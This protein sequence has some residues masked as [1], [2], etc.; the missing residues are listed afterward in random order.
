MPA[1]LP[2][3]P[4][5]L[6]TAAADP[7]SAL[8]LLD[9]TWAEVIAAPDDGRCWARLGTA[10]L[11][12][13][14][15]QA[16]WSLARRGLERSL[17]DAELHLVLALIATRR[18]HPAAAAEHAARTLELAP[19]TAQARALLVHA[20]C[21]LGRYQ[22]CFDQA[23]R[24]G[25]SALELATIKMRAGEFE[26]VL[27]ILDEAQVEHDDLLRS[28]A[29]FQL[30]RFEQA[31]AAAERSERLGTEPLIAAAAA[32]GALLEA[33]RLEPAESALRRASAL[34]PD[35]PAIVQLQHDLALA[36][37]DRAGALAAARRLTTLRPASPTA[38]LALGAALVAIEDF[39]GA[40]PPLQRAV[41]LEPELGAAYV[42]LARCTRQTGDLEAAARAVQRADQLRRRGGSSS[43]EIAAG[44]LLQKR[45]TQA[46]PLLEQARADAPTDPIIALR[47]AQ[48]LAALGREAE[49]LAA[50]DRAEALGALEAELC[51][52]R[53]ELKIRLGMATEA[54]ADLA[55]AIE[56]DSTSILGGRA[57]LALG[58]L[59]R[60]RGDFRGALTAYRLALAVDPQDRPAAAGLNQ[61]QAALA[62]ELWLD[63]AERSELVG[64]LAALETAANGGD[65]DPFAYRRLADVAGAHRQRALRIE[66]LARVELLRPTELAGAV[67]A[68][69]A[70]ALDGQFE[71]A[72]RTLARARLA[73][74]STE[75]AALDRALADAL[76]AGRR[77]AIDEPEL[78]PARAAIVRLRSAPAP[79]DAVAEYLEAGVAMK[80]QDWRR[81]RESLGRAIA[82]QPEY[83]RAWLQLGQ[84]ARQGGDL[85]A[86]RAAYARAAELDARSATARVNLGAVLARL[87]QLAAAEAALEAACAVDPELAEAFR[88]LAAVRIRLGK[89]TEAR[90]PLERAERLGADIRGLR[91]QLEPRTELRR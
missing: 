31:A 82:L 30:G 17:P 4:M 58:D 22:E 46:L 40:I 9:Q 32:A 23:R 18:H 37:G 36:Q 6:A 1:I 91:E 39:T 87:G 73:T 38:W 71:R 5:V 64:R 79:F 49:A 45:P 86:A 27:E 81:A 84:A 83:Y 25:A 21:A 74:G 19:A 50:Y 47:Y 12:L 13:G 16:A 51:A 63:T 59:R 33:R 53:G 7:P 10:Y 78:E 44:L 35:D 61:A 34:G 76:E 41:V 42:L 29:L 77:I 72:A 3:L 75:L 85:E 69:E 2:W 54:E 70:C 89:L 15:A 24:D 67:A 52:H 68:I 88:N 11:D 26:H 57:A 14:L 28:Q 55:R 65:A 80:Q 66:A 62:D 48:T 56:L 90:A 43:A 20:L 60:E 8:G